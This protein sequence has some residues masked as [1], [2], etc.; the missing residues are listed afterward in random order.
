MTCDHNYRHCRHLG[1]IDL[2][3]VIKLTTVFVV[4]V[5]LV[6]TQTGASEDLILRR[7]PR[8]LLRC[9]H[10]RDE[11]GCTCSSRYERGLMPAGQ[12]D[13]IEQSLDNAVKCISSIIAGVINGSFKLDK[14]SCCKLPIIGQFCEATPRFLE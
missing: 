6:A 4:A 1:R 3:S 11:R 7:V 9:D 8:H 13:T 2:S 14:G 10:L 12:K 5:L